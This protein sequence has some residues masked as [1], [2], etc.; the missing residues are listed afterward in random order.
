MVR[1]VTKEELKE[2]IDRGDAFNLVMIMNEWHYDAEHIPGTIWVDTKEKALELLRPNEEIVC[3]C[4][5]STCALSRMACNLL[6]KAGYQ[7][8]FHYKGGL[9]E[10]KEAGYPL[11]G[12]LIDST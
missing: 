12:E 2:K 10:W 7:H 5:D 4:S 11:E 6:E 8:V 1:E 9:R 3:Y